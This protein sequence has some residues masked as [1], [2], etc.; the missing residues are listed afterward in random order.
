MEDKFFFTSIFPNKSINQKVIKDIRG[1]PLEKWWGGDF[2][3]FLFLS[4]PPSL[5]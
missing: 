4:P 1:G 2:F 3:N 5:I